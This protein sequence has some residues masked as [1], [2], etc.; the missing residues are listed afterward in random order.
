MH[1]YYYDYV[2]YK[3][4]YNYAFLNIDMLLVGT[5]PTADSLCYLV[6]LPYK[7]QWWIWERG[8]TTLNKCCKK[9]G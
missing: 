7:N 6:R 8:K 4:F 5:K 1:S 3:R 2:D 9:T